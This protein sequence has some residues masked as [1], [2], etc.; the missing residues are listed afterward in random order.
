MRRALLLSVICIPSLA[1]IVAGCGDSTV[2]VA[3]DG[4]S[5]SGT[6]GGDTGT[7]TVPSGQDG[8]TGD[9]DAGLLPQRSSVTTGSGPTSV[10]VVDLNLDGKLDLVVANGNSSSV[11]VFLGEGDARFA[12]QATYGAG[13]DPYLVA[14]ADLNGDGKPDLAAIDDQGPGTLEILLNQGSGVLAPAVST[15]VGNGP[16]SLG[17]ADL[18]GDEKPDIFVANDA[19]GTVEALL[20]RGQGTFSALPPINT[21]GSITVFLADFNGDHFAD[22]A[23]VTLNEVAILLGKGDGTFQSPVSYPVGELASFVTA[24]DLDGDGKL[25]LAVT[26]T[27]DNTVSVLLGKGDGT[28]GAQT[29]YPT[30]SGPQGIVAADFDGH[31][32]RARHDDC[33]DQEPHGP[34][35]PRLP[36]RARTDRQRDIPE[37]ERLPGSG[38]CDDQTSLPAPQG[39]N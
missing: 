3:Q 5:D 20:N 32:Q 18:N 24:A 25:D 19:D 39:S 6:S 22:A 38:R 26:N 1:A 36:A 16:Q 4:A 15:T 23:V 12:S 7:Q 33:T 30:G 28:F 9:C 10:A 35:Q 14:A 37:Q 8:A 34:G 27:G 29:T 2:A 13:T 21:T 31:R 11:S 17:I